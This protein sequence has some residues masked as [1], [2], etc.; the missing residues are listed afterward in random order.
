MST[1]PPLPPPPYGSLKPWQ[2]SE[3]DDRSV[4]RRPAWRQGRPGWALLHLLIGFGVWIAGLAALGVVLAM[5]GRQDEQ[6]NRLDDRG[7]IFMLS[8]VG[9]I[10]GWF[11]FA[12]VDGSPARRWA[13]FG[14]VAGGTWLVALAIALNTTM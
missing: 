12:Y 4:D 2:A 3:P 9:A 8:L 10:V 13:I 14:C 11:L 7:G 1:P 5:A 6:L